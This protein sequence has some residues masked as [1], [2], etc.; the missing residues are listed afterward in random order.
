MNKIKLNRPE[1][2]EV[3]NKTYSFELELAERLCIE[4]AHVHKAR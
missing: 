2:V 3:K 1:T 4:S